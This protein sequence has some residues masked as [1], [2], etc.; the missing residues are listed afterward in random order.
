MTIRV[1]PALLTLGALLAVAG[2]IVGFSPIDRL[3]T[4]C[5]SAFRPN[6]ASAVADYTRAIRADAGGYE[7]YGDVSAVSDACAAARSDR[8]PLA[9]GGLLP[10]G[11]LFALG[12]GL[13]VR[14][15]NI[16]DELRAA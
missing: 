14:E 8:K 1:A 4:S 2:A 6:D 5:G 11:L 10:G 16:E 12:F 13:M 7:L 3:G 15:R 9:L